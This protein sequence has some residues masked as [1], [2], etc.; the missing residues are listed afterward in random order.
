MNPST[1]HN[2]LSTAVHIIR[3]RSELR[4]HIA[5]VLGSGLSGLAELVVSEAVIPYAEIPSFPALSVVGHPGRLVFGRLAGV[6]VALLQGRAHY[7]EGIDFPAITAPIRVLKKLGVDTLVLTNAAGGIR[8]EWSVGDIMLIIDHINLPGMA[9]NNPLRGPNDDSVGPRF[10]AMVSAY[11]FGL[12]GL[13]RDAA[14][15][16]HIPLREGVYAMVSGPNFETPAEIRFLK[17]IGADAVGMSTVPEV[18][19][20]RHSGIRCL[21][22]SYISNIAEERSSE[23][24]HAANHAEV[25]DVGAAVTPRFAALVEEIIQRI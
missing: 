9:G 13:A 4:P 14:I 1:A 23:P 2:D 19:V 10:P 8:R 12:I 7:Y 20:A 25:L 15:K 22:L 17:T 16:L 6:P 5:C 24:C 18:L 21:G 11:D 3:E